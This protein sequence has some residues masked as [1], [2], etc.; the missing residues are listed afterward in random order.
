MR[1]HLARLLLAAVILIIHAS[2]AVAQTD[3]RSFR[4]LMQSTVILDPGSLPPALA[5]FWNTYP[6]A[7]GGNVYAAAGSPGATAPTSELLTGWFYG[8]DSALPPAATP[9]AG[10]G[11]YGNGRGKDGFYLFA[12]GTHD[13]TGWHITDSFTLQLGQAVWTPNPGGMGNFGDYQASGE[14]KDGTGMFEGATGSFTLQGDFFFHAST[15]DPGFVARWNPNLV[16]K[17]CK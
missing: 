13:A 10:A 4:A 2:A 5:D 7:W 17:F 6:E 8:T 14:L 15:A 12:F 16:G 11:G 1:N 9:S 3:C